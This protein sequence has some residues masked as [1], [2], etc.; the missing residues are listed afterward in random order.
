MRERERKTVR[1]SRIRL[2]ATGIVTS[3]KG[4]SSVRFC[5]QFSCDL[6]VKNCWYLYSVCRIFR[7][8]IS[9][10]LH[11]F[12][13]F[14]DGRRPILLFLSLEFYYSTWTCHNWLY[15][16]IFWNTYQLGRFRFPASADTYPSMCLPSRTVFAR[17]LSSL[18]CMLYFWASH[19]I[20]IT[21]EIFI[22]QRR[23]F[24]WIDSVAERFGK[25]RIIFVSFH[26][27]NLRTLT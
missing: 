10:L 26:G 19:L 6:Q 1:E 12:D 13:G 20:W 23:H 9:R 5:S 11:I 8:V 2:V 25:L 21:F 17:Y 24:A 14:P 4:V 22:A 3:W 15:L 27:L 16:D 18:N 7:S